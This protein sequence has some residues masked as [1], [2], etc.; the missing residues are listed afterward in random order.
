MPKGVAKAGSFELIRRVETRPGSV[1]WAAQMSLRP[2][3]DPAG[4]ETRCRDS[5]R[6]GEV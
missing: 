3:T 2:V 4:A 6:C 5:A 1:I